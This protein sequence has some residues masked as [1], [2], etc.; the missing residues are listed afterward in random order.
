MQD[1]PSHYVYRQDVIEFV[2]VAA[3][4]CAYLEQQL[5]EEDKQ[6]MAER[7]LCLLPLLYLKTRM[8]KKPE[9]EMDGEMEQF[10]TEE[11]YEE[12]RSCV[13]QKLG[14]DDTYLD[15]MVED[16]KYTDQPVM[17]TI[18][19]NIADIYQ[20]LRDLCANYQTQETSVMNDA[21]WAALDAFEL[22][23]GQKLLN[24]LRALHVLSNDPDFMKGDD[25]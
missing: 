9:P 11:A 1:L 19:E 3:Q 13:E 23:W 14:S 8:L 17:C 15:V 12:V 21:V 5:P 4:T 18:S 24:A 25:E 2:T 20:V 7:L 16:S 22:H 10:C 6:L